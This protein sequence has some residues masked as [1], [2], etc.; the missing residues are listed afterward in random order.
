MGAY[1]GL[2]AIDLLILDNEKAP[3]LLCMKG[4]EGPS[5]SMGAGAPGRMPAAFF[6]SLMNH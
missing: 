2:S 6:T 3:G 1:T 4:G 5:G